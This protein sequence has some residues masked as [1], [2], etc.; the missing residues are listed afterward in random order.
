MQAT[1]PTAIA[2]LVPMARL[3]GS[4]GF[5]VNCG[6]AVRIPA[7]AV[8]DFIERNTIPTREDRRAG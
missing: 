5:T 2:A 7:N 8:A 1:S 3:V 4:L 6:R